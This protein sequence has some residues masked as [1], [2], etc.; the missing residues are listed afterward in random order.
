MGLHPAV[1]LGVDAVRRQVHLRAAR[2]IWRTVR[3]RLLPDLRMDLGRCTLGVGLGSVAVL[4]GGRSMALRLVWARL[5][6]VSLALALPTRSISWRL[7]VP[8]VPARAV[9]DWGLRAQRPRR[10]RLRRS[11]W[12]RPRRRRW[13]SASLT[14]THPGVPLP[15]K[16]CTSRGTLTPPS[17]GPGH[18]EGGS[19]HT[20]PTGRCDEVRRREVPIGQP[21]ANLPTG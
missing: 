20:T 2:R 16:A 7:R 13:R 5:V 1:R 18:V 11:G 4:R 6:A 9:P 8:R 21:V 19:A 17:S 14:L 12:W 3:V 10:P 15:R